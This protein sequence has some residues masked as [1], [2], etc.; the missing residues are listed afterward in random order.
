V[1]TTEI[2]HYSRP[3]LDE[4]PPPLPSNVVLWWLDPQ[5]PVYFVTRPLEARLGE[6]P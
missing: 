3:T 5:T 2:P 6:L 1:H 4:A